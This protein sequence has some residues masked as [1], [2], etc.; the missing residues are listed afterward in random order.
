VTASHPTPPRRSG[1]A[2][3]FQEPASHE[4]AVAPRIR[5]TGAEAAVPGCLSLAS[6]SPSGGRHANDEE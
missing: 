4:Q 2:R 3:L 5:G 1:G 6:A